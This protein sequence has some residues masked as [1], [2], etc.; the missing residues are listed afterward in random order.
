MIN[1]ARPHRLGVKQKFWW[2]S[3]PIVSV[4]EDGNVKNMDNKSS[5]FFSSHVNPQPY[6]PWEDGNTSLAYE[7]YKMKDNCEGDEFA[8]SFSVSKPKINA[9]KGDNVNDDKGYFVSDTKEE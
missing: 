6:D 2:K 9:E 1:K 7:D 5:D 8:P 3:S 4:W